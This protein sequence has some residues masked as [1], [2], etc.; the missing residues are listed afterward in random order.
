[1]LEFYKINGLFDIGLDEDETCKKVLNEEMFPRSNPSML[2]LEVNEM[3]QKKKMIIF[4][5][6][7]LY[8][9]FTIKRYEYCQNLMKAQ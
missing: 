4:L 5:K 3:S 6:K 8:L 2:K 7:N 1:M 9:R